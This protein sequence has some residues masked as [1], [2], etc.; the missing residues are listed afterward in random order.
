[1]RRTSLALAALAALAFTPVAS[2]HG[3][4]TVR[5]L[6]VPGWLFYYG[7]AAVLVASFV[8]L[9]ALWSKPTL[10]RAARGKPLPH[11][12]QR[13]ALSSVVSIALRG[14]S[15]FIFLLVWSAAIFGT[16][17]QF[18][19][20][21]PTFIYAVFW[22]GMPALV[23]LLGNVWTVLNPW[24]AAADLAAWVS[25]ALGREWQA[26]F[27]YPERLGYWPAAT[28][29][30]SFAAIELA[31]SDPGS[32]RALAV[33]IGLYSYIT[34]MG[35]AAVGRDAW[36]LNGDGFSVYFFLLSRLAAFGARDEDGRRVLI[37]RPPLSGLAELGPRVGSL[38]MVSVMLGSVAFDGFSRS[39]VWQRR[40]FS[41]QSRYVENPRLA[42][43]VG[44]LLNVA[45]LIAFIVGVALTFTLALLAARVLSDGRAQLGSTI[46]WSLVP[47]AFAY[48][49]AHYF[50]YFLIQSQYAIPLFSDPFGRGWDLL[51]TQGY[52]PNLGF[53]PPNT[54]WYV[55]VGALVV[56]HVAGLAVAHDRALTTLGTTRAALRSQYAILALMVL[57]TVGGL[58]L[59]SRG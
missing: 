40:L 46:V 25:R 16:T 48:V 2:A 36:T 9:G 12:L 18:E 57:Y 11:A 39:I 30:G 32:P 27:E 58:W 38:A 53:L 17:S 22:L 3:I 52:R 51:S 5:D 21:A 15:L 8:A 34:W 56:G 37:V 29:L 19:S 1:M 31:Y 47:I 55:Q 41:A 4:G 59:L 10:E 13:I 50:S 54:V 45:G 26:P 7:A 14:F 43:L 49:V 44:E 24:R 6:A 35:M 23:V 28:L 33:A 20:L 42:D